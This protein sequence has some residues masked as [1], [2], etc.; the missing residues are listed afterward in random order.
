MPLA[1]TPQQKA[2]IAGFVSITA[3]KDSVAAKVRYQLGQLLI[4]LWADQGSSGKERFDAL[5]P[6]ALLAVL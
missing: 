3:V 6:K 4:L 2:A 1:Y 5:P